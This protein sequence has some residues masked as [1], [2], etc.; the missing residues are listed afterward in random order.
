M[1]RYGFSWMSRPIV[2]VVGLLIVASIFAGYYGRRRARMDPTGSG[3]TG[4]A[5]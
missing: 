2:L 1:G 4:H 5:S 3:G